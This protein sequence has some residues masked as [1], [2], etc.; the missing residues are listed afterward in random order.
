VLATAAEGGEMRKHKQEITD[1]DTLEDILQRALVCRIALSEDNMP[2]IVPVCFGYKHGCIYIHSSR[3][4]RKMEI[5]R[6]NNKVCFEVDVD[7]EPVPGEPACKWTIKYRSVI[8][9]G[10]AS[11]V[12]DPQQ[13]IDALNVVMEHYSGRGSHHYEP[14]P[15]DLTAIIKIEIE[16]MTG[17][18]SKA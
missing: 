16:S 15:L 13:K 2:Y 14:H 6:T 18:R 3:H 9:F 7:V 12:E 1:K 4:G 11:I 8:G 17:K 5:I 10:T